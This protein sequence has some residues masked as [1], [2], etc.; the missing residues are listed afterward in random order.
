MEQFFLLYNL[1]GF[2][3][4]YLSMERE[5]ELH[6]PNL[7][8]TVFCATESEVSVVPPPHLF[9]YLSLFDT[10]EKENKC[11]KIILIIKYLFN[12]K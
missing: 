3:A 10:K 8:W 2:K 1:L 5:R 11:N 4:S 12:D 9:S 6:K 7:N